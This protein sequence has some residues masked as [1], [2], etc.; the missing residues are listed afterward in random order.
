MNILIVGLGSIAKK[1]I[2]AL[3]SISNDFKIY[4]LRTISNNDDEAGIENIFNLNDV[5]VIFDF[6]IISNPTN[7][8]FEYIQK[9]AKKGINLFVKSFFLLLLP[10]C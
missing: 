8:H 9:L 6:A 10:L 2:T 5:N 1:H 3:K 4:A 7:L